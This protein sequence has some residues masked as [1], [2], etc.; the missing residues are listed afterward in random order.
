[1]IKRIATNAILVICL[2][3]QS[4]MAGSLGYR[5][6][7]AHM[8]WEPYC[9]KPDQPLF[10]IHDI[11]SYNFAVAEYNSYLDAVYAYLDCLED[12][13][14]ADTRLTRRAI[15]NGFETQQTNIIDELEDAKNSLELSRFLID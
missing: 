2:S 4:L 9:L 6:I 11:Q 8:D 10:F 12:E 14:E 7:T 13:V 3:N 15:I 1:M 5:N